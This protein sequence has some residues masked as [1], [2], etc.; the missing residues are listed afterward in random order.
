MLESLTTELRAGRQLAEA[1]AE[2]AL[3]AIL[4]DDPEDS[5]IA[6][7]LIALAEKGESVDEIAGFARG[8]RRLCVPIRSGRPDLV[9]TAGTGGGRPTFNIST[10][11]AFVIA[12]SGVAV[13]KHGNRAATSRCGSADLLEELG[14]RV[15]R[16]AEV[17]ER[18]LDEIGICFLFAP[19]YHPAMKRVARIRREL[20]RRTIFNMIGP[21]TNPASAPFQLIG[22]YAPE[23]T[24]KL[25]GAL[26][27]LGCRHAWVVHGT[28]GLDEVSVWAGT[29]V[30]RVKD[31]S[32][33]NFILP[34]NPESTVDFPSGGSP[35]E[36]A[37]LVRGILDGSV[38]GPARGVVLLNARVA[39]AIVT[40]MAD[41]EAAELAKSV[42]DDGLANRKLDEM[43]EI[44]A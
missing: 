23:L 11:A 10:A 28:D 30:T 36:N 7:F 8:M 29:K 34:V 2:R 24:E 18:A 9:D 16:P 6:D 15:D 27:R 31:G 22:V 26:L 20:G 21:L 5:V 40:G 43:V 33:E 44:Y 12:A 32:L 38:R 3:R 19:L 39:I 13:A 37:R 17:S 14:V 41:A 25:G 35:A 4:A 1:E 42:L